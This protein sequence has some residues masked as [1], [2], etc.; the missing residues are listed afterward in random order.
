[1]NIFGKL[2]VVFAVA[3]LV[4]IAASMLLNE[5]LML[6]AAPVVFIAVYL[7]HLYIEQSFR[8]FAAGARDRK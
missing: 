6:I 1:M 7:D 8:E 5:A 2:S 4:L 3:G